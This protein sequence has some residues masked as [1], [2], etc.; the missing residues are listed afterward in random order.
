MSDRSD[1]TTLG[2]LPTG[3]ITDKKRLI[4]LFQRLENDVALYIVRKDRERK[5]YK[6]RKLDEIDAD[7]TII[8]FDLEPPETSRGVINKGR[9]LITSFVFDNYFHAL[10]F[11]LLLKQETLNGKD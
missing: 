7:G 2:K 11:E 4:E 10:A 6:I 9:H 1:D 5:A 3:C 8:F